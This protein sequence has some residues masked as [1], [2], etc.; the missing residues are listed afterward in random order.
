[1]NFDYL[2]LAD[3]IQF[4]KCIRSIEVSERHTATFECELSFD[5]ATVTWY[6]D[7]WELK[8]SPK[9]NFRAEGRR[10][11]MIICN[12]TAE[13]EGLLPNMK[14]GKKKEEKH[15]KVVFKI[16]N[17]LTKS[18]EWSFDETNQLRF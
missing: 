3:K 16:T 14:R 2:V 8:E 11:F 10:H 7:S 5:N 13:D 4:T 9:Y 1:M 17:V 6:K 12:V 15:F 18:R